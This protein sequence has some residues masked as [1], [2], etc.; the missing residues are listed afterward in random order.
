MKLPKTGIGEEAASLAQAKASLSE[1][2]G[3]PIEN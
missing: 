3:A 1:L 2:G